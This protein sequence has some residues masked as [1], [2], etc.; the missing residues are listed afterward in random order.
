MEPIREVFNPT[1]IAAMAT[2]LAQHVPGFDR[3]AFLAAALHDL[4]QRS[5]MQR[6]DRLYTLLR[7]HLAAPFPE[8]AAWLQ[9]CL[10]PCRDGFS[11]Q[12][13]SQEHGIQGWLVLPIAE[14]AGREGG[15]HLPIALELLAQCTMRFTAEFGIRHLWAS[16]PDQVMETVSR[17]TQHE[18]EHVRRLVSEGARPLLPWGKRLPL[19]VAEPQRTLPLLIALIDDPSPYVRKSVANHLNDIAR[20]HPALVADF[21]EQWLAD[22]PPPRQRLLRHALRNLLKQGHPQALALYQLAAP[23]LEKV[24]LCLSTDQVRLGDS[25]EIS[26]DLSSASSSDQSLRLDLIVHYQKAAGTMRPKVFRWKDF[27][28]AALARHQARKKIS[29]RPITT[30][31]Y[32]AGPHRIELQVNGKVCAAADFSLVV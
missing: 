30:R 9:R 22:A 23:A 26:L 27:T 20:H 25:L 8:A 11:S 2:T 15:A 6:S 32:H 29:F 18:N 21:A 4:D 5:L 14:F 13:N 19:F 7:D 12:K 10:H 16:Q 17:W 28:L 24:S 1:S 31:T 3:P